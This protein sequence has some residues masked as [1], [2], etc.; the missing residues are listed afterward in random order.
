MLCMQAAVQAAT[1]MYVHAVTQ[2]HLGMQ[3]S[4]SAAAQCRRVLRAQCML[5]MQHEYLDTLH[6]V[7]SRMQALNACHPS[8]CWWRAALHSQHAGPR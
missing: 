1:G 7:W 5:C 2:L 4:A 3:R 8:A 6:G